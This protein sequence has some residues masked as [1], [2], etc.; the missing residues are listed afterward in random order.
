MKDNKNKQHKNQINS[1]TKTVSF[2]ISQ[3]KEFSILFKRKNETLS[4]SEPN[5]IIQQLSQQL[6]EALE[7]LEKVDQEKK[8][9][10]EIISKLTSNLNEAKS[11]KKKFQEVCNQTVEFTEEIS[12]LKETI[13]EKGREIEKQKEVNKTLEM[14]KENE[15]SKIND[16]NKKTSDYLQSQIADKERKISEAY[17]KMEEIKNIPSNEKEESLLKHQKILEDEK[18][19]LENDLAIQNAKLMALADAYKQLDSR[20]QQSKI[21]Y[22]Q[23]IQQVQGRQTE[24]Q[25]SNQILNEELSKIKKTNKDITTKLN[26]AL[27]YIKTLQTQNETLN[28]KIDSIKKNNDGVMEK[29]KTKANNASASLVGLEE[30]KEI[31]TEYMLHL[32]KQE[33][34]MTYNDITDR[35]LFNFNQIAQAAFDSIN[36]SGSI[37]IYHENLKD[38]YFRI[39]CKANPDQTELNGANVSNETLNTITN[40]IFK[41]NFLDILE[42]KKSVDKYIGKLSSLGLDQDAITAIINLYDSKAK[43]Y[44]QGVMSSIKALV[45]KCLNTIKNGQIEINKKKLFSFKY[46]FASNTFIKIN[47]LII[48][49]TQLTE[50][51]TDYLLILI[52]YPYEKIKAIEMLGKFSSSKISEKSI[53]KIFF[54]LMTYLTSVE[55][56][57]LSS[58]ELSTTIMNNVVFMLENMKQLISIKL[59]SSILTDDSIKMLSDVLKN[60]KTLKELHLNKN[61]ITSSGAFFLADCLTLNKTIKMLSLAYNKITGE[62]LQTLFNVISTE[63]STIDSIDLSYNSFKEGDFATLSS[64]LINNPKIITLSL[65]GNFIDMQSCFTLGASFEKA[66]NLKVL[67]MSNMSIYS[68]FAPLLFKNLQI[69]ELILD[70]NPL[71][72]IGHIML[73]K[74]LH[75]NVSVKKISLKNTRISAIGLTHVLNCINLNKKMEEVHLELNELDDNA[76]KITSSFAKDK[77]CLIFISKNNVITQ[78]HSALF[79]T[80]TNVVL[81]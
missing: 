65:S 26:E 73:A 27:S 58:T 30:V 5:K 17:E 78:I 9:Y 77:T 3:E 19:H 70:E 44:Q 50:E 35:T 29:L 48:D 79:E 45:E 59:E 41:I 80:L 21:E 11:Y 40:E 81:V 4:M 18:Q 54:H 36:S 69:E 51:S 37:G 43:R 42:Q 12:K 75:S 57:S 63:N 74:A 14:E 56:F 68:D 32:F 60:N 23:N 76:L 66:T 6:T 13:E 62:G 8:Q 64:F 47:H 46:F 10:D 55:S 20:F 67:N 49:N 71:D 61:N 15:I 16:L 22:E 34:S 33:Q 25:G 24:M 53:K 7:Q 38:L 72:E 39:Y 1:S 28:G 2:V 52:K 31:I